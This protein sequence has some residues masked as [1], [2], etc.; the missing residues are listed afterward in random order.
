LAAG[1]GALLELGHSKDKAEH[2]AQGLRAGGALVSVRV[3]QDE[4]DR[5]ADI[6]DDDVHRAAE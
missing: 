2:F 5:F 6:L 1:V 4:A 3:P